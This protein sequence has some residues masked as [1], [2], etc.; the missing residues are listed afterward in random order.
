MANNQPIESNLFNVNA[1]STNVVGGNNLFNANAPIPSNVGG[2][3]LL[4]R[5]K[6]LKDKVKVIT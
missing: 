5:A 1:P 2:N 4:I 3:N 6:N